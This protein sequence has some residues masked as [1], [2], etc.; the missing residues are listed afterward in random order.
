MVETNAKALQFRAQPRLQIMYDELFRPELET[1]AL[2]QPVLSHGDWSWIRTSVF[3]RWRDCDTS[4]K[5]SVTLLIFSASLELR[6]RYLDLWK[7]DL[8]A[9]LVDPY[10]LLVVCLDELWKQAQSI[11]RVVSD[12]F[13]DMERTALDIAHATTSATAESQLDFVGLHNM[14]KHIIYLKEGSAATMLTVSH[15]QSFHDELVKQPPQGHDA[16]PFTRL[17]HQMLKQKAVQFEVW[18]LR[19]TSLEKR[20]QN[21]INLAFNV[22]TQQDSRV[23]KYDSKSMKAIASVTMVF[24]PLATV[25]TV[26]GSQFFNFDSEKKK[27]LVANNFWIFW[28]LIA[29]LCLIVLLS[30]YYLCYIRKTRQSLAPQILKLKHVMSP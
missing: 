30:Y 18:E 10:S 17:T 7:N 14:A 13:S 21:I 12:E 2:G 24:L 20:I 29:P 4:D 25:A 8:S 3:M 23:L 27:I 5:A 19:M 22:V 16:I 6:Q 1:A 28:A 9:I 26:F 11:V 15:L